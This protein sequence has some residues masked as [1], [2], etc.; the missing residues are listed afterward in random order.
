[1]TT[2]TEPT[3]D[4]RAALDRALLRSV[5]RVEP[6]GAQA[7]ETVAAKLFDGFFAMSNAEDEIID[8]LEAA[9][10]PDGWKDMWWDHYDNSLEIGPCDPSFK[11]PAS[12]VDAVWA[13]GFSTLFVNFTNDTNTVYSKGREPH[14][15]A[16]DSRKGS[17]YLDRRSKLE[18]IES[19]QRDLEAARGECSAAWDKC[20]ERR[21]EAESL[22]AQLASAERDAARLEY[23]LPLLG[24]DDTTEADARTMR[25]AAGIMRGLD[26]RAAIDAALS[27][28]AEQEKT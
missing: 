16:H 19:L 25:I 20:E 13:L 28:P 18:R 15:Y 27:P 9:G 4:E 24:G 1:M 5:K 8:A 11:V 3:E 23:V 17:H 7:D 22:R 6:T 14:T 2:P 21:L 12:A 10:L 26:A